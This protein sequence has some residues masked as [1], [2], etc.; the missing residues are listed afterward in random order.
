VAQL[1]PSPKEAQSESFVHVLLQTP[2]I[3]PSMQ[4][5]LSEPQ[6]VASTPASA[7]EQLAPTSSEEEELPHP[8]SAVKQATS[9]IKPRP[10]VIMKSSSFLGPHPGRTPCAELAHT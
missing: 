1:I 9:A 6:S 8:L 3:E 2:G 10:N 5:H 7:A 4:R